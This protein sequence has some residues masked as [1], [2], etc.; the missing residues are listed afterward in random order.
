MP[1]FT[2]QPGSLQRPQSLAGT[3]AR[4]S[5]EATTGFNAPLLDLLRQQ[6]KMD[7]ISYGDDCTRFFFAKAKQRKLSTYIYSLH[8]ASGNEVGDVILS[9]YKG[10]L[11]HSSLRRTP[12]DPSIFAQGE[13]LSVEHQL[14]LC[15]PF[16]DTDI[17]EAMFS[18]PNHKSP[19][20][21]G[22]SSAPK[23]HQQI[24]CAI[25]AA[26]IYFIWYAR[27][28]LMFKNH[29]I[30]AQHTV[31]MIKTQIRHRILFLNSLTCTFSSYVDGL[32]S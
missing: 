19:G 31:R 22:Y 11:G 15:K 17:K 30:S 20:P 13:V 4:H 9:Y 16:T 7:W 24:S 26:T 2:T 14:E 1:A 8:D 23:A 29:R 3:I 25:F 27:N 12:V 32:L 28:Q 5:P 10:H 21:D 18:I 6:C